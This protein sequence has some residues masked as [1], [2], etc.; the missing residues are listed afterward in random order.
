V[1]QVISFSFF[2]LTLLI[3]TF[4]NCAE[5]L[6]FN[7]SSD[8][9]S[10]TG[11]NLDHITDYHLSLDNTSITF[12]PKDSEIEINGVCFNYESEMTE[13]HFELAC[14][15]NSERCFEWTEVLD[16]NQSGK[17]FKTKVP[18][19]DFAKIKILNGERAQLKI[20]SEVKKLGTNELM[21]TK[22]ADGELVLNGDPS[23]IIRG[24]PIGYNTLEGENV[25]I[26]VSTSGNSL[27]HWEK[28]GVL[29]P[30]EHENSILVQNI[31]TTDA[32]KY[33]I[34]S[35]YRYVYSPLN[36]T[37]A[38][39]QPSSNNLLG[40]IDTVLRDSNGD[41][42]L[43]GWACLKTFDINPTIEIFV[44][45]EKQLATDKADLTSYVDYVSED[46]INS[47][48]ENSNRN[49]RYLYKIKKEFANAHVGQPIYIYATLNGDNGFYELTNSGEVTIPAE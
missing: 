23:G 3:L 26:G 7:G 34:H 40:F 17:V 38:S 11:R 20:R 16:C 2:I 30:N 12:T 31:K 24:F 14:N 1:S 41:V 15:L 46:A 4:Q 19:L 45:K 39:T 10:Q 43:F 13:I 8:Q 21:N 22:F 42:A 32:G 48:C 47:L 49:L 36:I 33:I 18:L 25:V 6:N 37:V 44:G 28:D 5:P 35:P 29:I 27:F 9:N